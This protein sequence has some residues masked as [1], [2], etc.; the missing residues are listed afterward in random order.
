GTSAFD[1]A[2]QRALRLPLH[3][4]R[5]FSWPA[6]S[7]RRRETDEPGRHGTQAPS[8]AFG[9]TF[10]ALV[11]MRVVFVGTGAIGVPTLRALQTSKHELVGVVTQPDKPV[12]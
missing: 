4:L 5:F 8:R 2:G 10:A 11:H 3:G 7:Y 9:S 6:G 1:S 12:G